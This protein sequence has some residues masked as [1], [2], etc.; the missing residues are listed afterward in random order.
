MMRFF[1]LL[2][3]AIPV[4]ALAQ[5]PPFAPKND[6]QAGLD[7]SP[8]GATAY[9]VEWNGEWGSN[10]AS[11]R[12]IYVSTL[13]NDEWTAAQVAPFSGQYSDDDPFVSPDGRWLYFVSERPA[14]DDDSEL[15]ADIWRYSVA[16][17]ERLQHLNINSDAAEYSP[18]VTASGALY[19]AS[20]REGGYGQGDL[21]KAAA[22][23]EKFAAPENLGGAVN[24]STG[25]WNLWVSASEYDLIFE[26]SSRPSNV[27]I[28]GDLYYSW[29]TPAGWTAATPLEDLNTRGSELLPRLHPDGRTL[30]YTTALSGEHARIAATD[31][32]SL[33]ADTRSSYAPTLLVAN[34]SSHDVSLVDLARGEVIAAVGTGEGPHLLSNVSDG[35]VLATGYGEF[36]RPHGR[37]VE[38]RPPFVETLNSRVTLIDVATQFVLLE[39]TLDDCSKP[40]ASWIVGRSAYVTCE[41]EQRVAVVDLESGRTTGHFDTHQQGSHVLAF[42][43]ESRML[44]VSNTESG[45]VTLIDIDNGD[46]RVVP[47]AAGSEGSLAIDGQIWV[48]NATDGSISLI[49][50]RSASVVKHIDAV[51]DFP[52]A[53]SAEQ[54]NEVWLACFASAELV[55][56][57]RESFAIGLRIKL[58]EPPLNLVTHP[59]RRLAYFSFPRQNAVAEIDLESGEELRRIRVGIEPDGLRWEN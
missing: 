7:F 17:D 3:T 14:G 58:R 28:P 56:I 6:N 51:C 8:D 43:P 48:A 10:A 26:A 54:E 19:F 52:I 15:D 36:P 12:T 2:L 13:E 33:R 57:D 22:K 31:W 45:S 21:Y 32:Q 11:R 5:D 20:A 37:P 42:E 25:E 41:S 55:A 59:S 18:V 47:L 23:G 24:R 53:F 40:H 49:D 44:A 1:C 30:Y 4:N 29:R 39:T 35:R 9:W 27:S 16:G 46:T 34:R 50:P 38:T